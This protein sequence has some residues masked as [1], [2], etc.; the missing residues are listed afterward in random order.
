MD[1]EGRRETAEDGEVKGNDENRQ[2]GS[3]ERDLM[4]RLMDA[5]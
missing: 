2:E 4:D 5:V 1:G 3:T